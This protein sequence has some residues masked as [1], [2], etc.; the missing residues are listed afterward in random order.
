LTR[1]WQSFEDVQITR[2]GVDTVAFLEAS[3][4]LVD[5]FGTFCTLRNVS[6]TERVAPQTSLGQLSSALSRRICER[7]SVCV[8]DILI[9]NPGTYVIQGVR[10]RY[11]AHPEE[12]STLEKLVTA[13]KAEG[14]PQTPG[15]AC[16]GRLLRCART[17]PLMHLDL[18]V[19]LR[20]GL[21]FT[22]R[23]LQTMLAEHSLTLVEC[24]R[25]AYDNTLA[26]HH[27]FLVRKVVGVAIRAVPHRPDFYARISQSAPDDSAAH[28]R[29]DEKMKPWLEALENIVHH[30]KVWLEE[31]QWGKVTM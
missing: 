8:Y 4:G 2:D 12:S 26:H 16:L 1:S 19:P 3:D 6:L 11:N 24:F 30:M 28:A 20:S 27:A 21:A 15:T 31:K 5:L 25:R 9:T 13:E 7:I 18:T 23:A 17:P 10:E 14:A 22:M 29:M